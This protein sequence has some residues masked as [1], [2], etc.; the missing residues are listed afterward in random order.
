MSY[1]FSVI[2]QDQGAAARARRLSLLFDR[3]VLLASLSSPSLDGFVPPRY[4]AR[5]AVPLRRR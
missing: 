5:I 3:W 4:S 1:G 2:T